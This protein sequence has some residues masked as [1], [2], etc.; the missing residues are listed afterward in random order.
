MKN[1]KTKQLG[2]FE[3]VSGL[4][5][6]IIFGLTA[7]GINS[8]KTSDSQQETACVESANTAVQKDTRCN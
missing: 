6:L 3:P 1:V 4:T 7:V 8:T 2:F 5:L